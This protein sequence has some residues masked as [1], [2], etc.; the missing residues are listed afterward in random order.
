MYAQLADYHVHTPLCHHAS[1]WPMEFAGRAVELGL[2]DLGFA[3]H[4]PMSASFDDW[5]MMREDLPRYFE[6]VEKAREAY[7]GLKIRL[8][9]ECDFIDGREE[10][11]EE[12]RGMAEWD[13]F[14][15]SVHYLPDGVEVD[16]PKYVGRPREGGVEGVWKAYHETYRRAIRSGLFDFMAHPDLPK[17]FGEIP[18]GD[19]RRFYEP[20]IGDLL[21]MGTPFEMNTA[22]WRKACAEQYPARGFLEMA[23]ASGVSLLINSDAHAVEDLGRDFEK[24]VELALAVGFTRTVRFDRRKVSFVHL[25]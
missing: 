20:V 8:G 9:L 17:K 11:I 7:P 4:N 23:A 2:G 15:G 3:D 21:E 12:L 1:G 19:L 22:G 24:A 14:I 25:R 6:E 10:W 13:Y 18:G 5:R 16:H